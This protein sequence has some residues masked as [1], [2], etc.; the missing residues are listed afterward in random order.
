MIGKPRAAR[1]VGKANASCDHFPVVPC[2][3]IRRADG[4]LS[5]DPAWVKM[6]KIM[7]EREQDAV[8]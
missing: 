4:G 7:I 1:A 5:G 2:H 3:R 8:R 6:Q